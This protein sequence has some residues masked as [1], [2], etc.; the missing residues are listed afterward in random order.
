MKF[1]TVRH[2]PAKYENVTHAAD[3]EARDLDETKLP[4][5][6]AKALEFARSLDP[7]ETVTVWSSPLPRS[8][9]TAKIFLEAMAERGIRIRKA[10]IFRDLEE[11]RNFRW[12]DF[13]A[14]VHGGTLTDAEGK[15]W[16][17]DVSVTNPETLSTGEYFRTSGWTKVPAEYLAGFPQ[18]VRH[19]FEIEPYDA[20][21]R[22]NLA[23]LERLR[24]VAENG[25]RHRVVTFSHQCC[26]DFL[27]ELINDYRQG[28]LDPAESV[29][30]DFVDGDFT[31]SELP[32]R[33]D[34]RT[35]ERVIEETRERV[36]RAAQ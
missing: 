34:G 35:M 18:D 33:F 12:T 26:S 25:K 1:T 30:L 20:I 21:V 11:A 5:V 15:D 4:D 36:G 9:E 17:V 13:A 24:R 19:K 28:G 10:K 22:R 29:T 31:V 8:L 32:E 7:E 27:L 2:G 16:H 3:F 6:R 23:F 14:I